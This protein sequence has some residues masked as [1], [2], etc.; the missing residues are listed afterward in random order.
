MLSFVIPAHNEEAQIGQALRTLL[1][2][3]GTVGESY[4]VIVVDDASTDRTAEIARS[5]G[6]TIVSA[7]LRKISA[8]RN[9]G[10]RAA[11]GDVL[12]FIDADTL[13][14]AKTLAALL[15]VIRQGA[16]G[17]GAR[18][19]MDEEVPL[20]GKALTA[21]IAGTMYQLGLA[22]GCFMFA[23]RDVFEAAGGF[24][25]QYYASEEIHLSLA[26]G[27]HGRFVMLPEPV[28][29]SSRKFRLFTGWEFF[30]QLV[31]LVTGGMDALKRRDALGFWYGGR[32]ERTHSTDH[33]AKPQSG[34]P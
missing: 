24:D 13:L 21:L 9:A 29:T 10:A 5:F 11:R 22:C 33:L 14:P 4:E 28:I 3:A 32:R 25:E 20:W 12:I 19:Q 8:V 6:A 26:L 2:S 23:R 16:A 30:Q 1:T 7:N 15:E 17:G 34:R 18:L 31:D 27:K